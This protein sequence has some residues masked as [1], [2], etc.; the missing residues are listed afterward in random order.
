M[1]KENSKKFEKILAG[2]Q[3]KLDDIQATINDHD[4]VKIKE[5]NQARKNTAGQTGTEVDEVNSGEKKIAHNTA[6][7]EAVDD[8][9]PYAW[10]AKYSVTF[11]AGITCM[12]LY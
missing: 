7:K 12:A 8:S 5:H 11:L 10:I 6:P 9:F 2:V 4:L 3:N 1:L